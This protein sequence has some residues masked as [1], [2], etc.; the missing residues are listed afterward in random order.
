MKFKEIFSQFLKK[1]KDLKVVSVASCNL[2]R[3]PN[4]A[5]KMLV[6]IDRPNC[7]FFLDYKFTRTYSNIRK[8]PQLSISFM[9]DDAFEGYRL[10]GTC[11]ILETG[12]EYE[13]IKK[14]WEKRV[15]FYT[16]DRI[17][18]RMK[19]YSTAR[20]AEETL[21]KNFVVVKFLAKEGSVVKPDRV[22]RTKK[23]KKV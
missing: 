12:E 1:K 20:E 14:Y 22:L 16:A 10:T 6:D 2:K 13:R 21:P 15:S 11:K 8:N 23:V 5:P 19:G 17:I 7:I 4:S 9:D 18:K 3:V